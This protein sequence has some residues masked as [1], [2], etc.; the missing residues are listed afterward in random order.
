MRTFPRPSVLDH[1]VLVLSPAEFVE[2]F[3]ECI[4]SGREPGLW[5][6][7]QKETDPRRSLRLLR[8]GGERRKDETASKKDEPDPPHEHLSAGWLAGV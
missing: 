6:A 1:N 7:H 8:S 5:G 2:T 4:E 3:A